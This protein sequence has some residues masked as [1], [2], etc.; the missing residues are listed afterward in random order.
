MSKEGD[1]VR[2]LLSIE[3][4]EMLV[5]GRSSAS[6]SVMS[7]GSDFVDVLSKKLFTHFGRR[8]FLA[9]VWEY[10]A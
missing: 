6:K 1:P 3:S 9:I 8:A 5:T 4:K 10:N 7:S 2:K